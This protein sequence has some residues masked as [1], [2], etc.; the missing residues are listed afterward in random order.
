MT[1]SI[2]FSSLLDSVC[3]AGFYLYLIHGLPRRARSERSLPLVTAGLTA[4]LFALSLLFY[5]PFGR[6]SMLPVL[7]RELLQPMVLLAVTLFLSP[8]SPGYAAFL[9]LLFTLVAGF[10]GII[11]SP[12]LLYALHLD[13]PAAFQWMNL[14]RVP[15]INLL[16]LLTMALLKRRFF[17]LRANC[18]MKLRESVLLLTPALVNH[19]LFVLLYTLMNQSAAHSFIRHYAPALY[20]LAFVL[21]ISSV[22]VLLSTER[23]FH[24]LDLQSRIRENALLMEREQLIYQ[25]N[26]QNDRLIRRTYHDL[27]NHL[28][29]LRALP[30]QQAINDYLDQLSDSLAPAGQY[31]STGNMILD[32]LLNQKYSLCRDKGIRLYATISLQGVDFLSQTD[33]CALFGNALDN[34]IEAAEKVPGD[35]EKAIWVK[36]GVRGNFLS[37]R[38][39]NPID[40]SLTL[41]PDGFPLTTKADSTAHG[42]GI[43]SMQSVLDRFQG[44]MTFTQDGSTLLLTMLIPIPEQT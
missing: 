41:G 4:A 5:L 6:S 24:A 27:K 32:I 14:L 3:R 9:V 40:G 35:E 18:T 25:Q 43:Y 20:V 39:T 31:F 10:W 12:L 36:G 37:V 22:F 11:V 17:T 19:C 26:Q 1:P 7:L 16:R 28:V 2:L 42:I 8:V 13:S 21:L 38:I 15:L 23:Y 29:A 30:D 34:S 33:L 44:Q